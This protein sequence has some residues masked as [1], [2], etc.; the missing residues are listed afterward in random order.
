MKLVVI[1]SAPIVQKEGENYLYAPYEKEMQ[2]WAKHANSIQF[3]CPIWK[4]DKKLL[5]APISFETT[6]TIEL[7]EFD[8]TSFS[9]MLRAIPNAFVDLIRIF[10][11]MKKADHIHLRCPGNMAL[12]A[13]V[14]QIFFPKKVKTAKYA[15]NWDPKARQ[16]FTYKLQRWILSN[17]ILTKNIQVLVYGDWENQ[18]KNIK[19]FFTATYSESEILNANFRIQNKDQES[20][21]FLFVGTL[22]RGKQPLYA[23][24]IVEELFKKGKNVTLDLFGDG[25][26]KSEIET[27]IRNKNL[28]SIIQLKGNQSKD[29]ILTA[30]QNSHFLILPSKSEG[31]PKVVAEAMFWG[32][33]PIASP[34][35]CI[36]Y[37]MGNGS[38]GI[39]LHEK[40]Q[41]DIN[42]IDMVINNQDFYHKIASEGQ[43][44]SQQF[45]TDRFEAEISKLLNG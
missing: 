41:E 13:A 2:L 17:T 9:N 8:I 45:T 12:L 30:Y 24:Q 6:P 40:I 21:K 32:C 36:S 15:G 31:W 44:W 25:A 3:C 20:I 43:S 28:E 37:M 42:Q 18:T 38:R 23:I 5:I 1:S 35:S 26:M 19:P 11:A 27:Y 22:S 39:L 34:V 7:K 16:P 33:V 4:E 29:A 14:V 10:E